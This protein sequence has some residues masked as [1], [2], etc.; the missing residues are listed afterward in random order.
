M[1]L[2]IFVHYKYFRHHPIARWLAHACLVLLCLLHI[3]SP[4]VAAAQ[5]A[6]QEALE[7]IERLLEAALNEGD[8]DTRR[9]LAEQVLL[10]FGSSQQSSLSDLYGSAYAMPPLLSPPGPVLPSN[11]EVYSFAFDEKLIHLV[12]QES[13]VQVYEV[14][15]TAERLATAIKYYVQE[16]QISSSFNGMERGSTELYRWLVQPY[17][18]ELQQAGIDRLIFF[19]SD[20]L[21]HLPLATLFDGRR[22]LIDDFEVVV[23]F[24]ADSVRSSDVTPPQLPESLQSSITAGQIELFLDDVILSQSSSVLTESSSAF[25]LQGSHLVAGA[26]ANLFGLWPSN[27]QSTAKLLDLF[28]AGLGDSPEYAAALR[29]AQLQLKSSTRFGHPFYWGMFQLVEQ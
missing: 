22:Y 24:G 26:K 6:D 3:L 27:D 9:E 17:A 4:T 11:A 23:S 25:Q 5:A 28:V 15:V 20:P 14:E 12:R 21:R 13:S 8:E 19:N 16:L 29:A 7:N 10:E 18:A 2:G 1:L